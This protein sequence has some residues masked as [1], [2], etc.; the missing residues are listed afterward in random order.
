MKHTAYIESGNS[1]EAVFNETMKL[2][3]IIPG[4]VYNIDGNGLKYGVLIP[5]GELKLCLDEWHEQ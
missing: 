5:T 1:G 3:G 2:T 4:G